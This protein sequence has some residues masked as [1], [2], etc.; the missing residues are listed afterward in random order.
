MA[1]RPSTSGPNWLRPPG[2]QTGLGYYIA[3]LRERWLLIAAAVLLCLGAAGLYLATADK[4]YEAEAQLLVTPAGSDDTLLASLGVIRATSDPTRDVQTAAEFVTTVDVAD[5]VQQELGTEG[6]GSSLV[7][8]VT[9]EPVG[10]S[11]IVAITAQASSAQ[12]AADRAN[13][14]ADATVATRTAALHDRID[15]LIEQINA[16][17]SAI[18]AQGEQSLKDETARLE[19]LRNGPDPTISVENEATPPNGATSP[20]PKLTLAA[21]LVGGLVI[22]IAAAFAAQTLDPRLRR[23][24]QLRAHYQL[25]ILTRVPG[26][27][28]QV[29]MPLLPTVL[30]PPTREAY[31]A[32]RANIVAAHWRTTLSQAVLVT[33]SS[34]SEGKTTTAINL[35]ASLSMT[36]AET[37]LIEA[38]LRRPSIGAAFGIS[39][40]RGVV[41]TLL[42]NAS[43]SESIVHTDFFGP[44]KLLLADRRGGWT[45]ELFSPGAAERLIREAKEIADFVVIDSP[46]LTA[47]IDA[48]PLAQQADDVVIV[49]RPGVTRLDKLRELAELLE[50]NG[51]D[52]LGFAVVGAAMRDLGYAYYATGKSPQDEDSPLERPRAATEES[53]AVSA[54]R[55]GPSDEVTAR[56]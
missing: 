13:A 50:A 1:D 11:A 56:P 24:E 26:Q 17:A 41:S 22:G 43:V 54:A 40:E 29:N 8:D 36:G 55:R 37:I 14:F 44:L 27:R 25:P 52:P 42:D 39:P 32:L 30:T 51:V 35:A 2:E 23:E 33:G 4:V 34:P 21:A 47:V 6:S 48:L 49:V 9:A 3:V 31:R 38:D 16:G 10:Q 5:R 15:H 20:K 53:P 46:P 12:A 28:S 7:G 19:L 18:T 45:S